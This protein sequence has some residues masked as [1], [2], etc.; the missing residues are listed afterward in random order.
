MQ[1]TRIPR[2]GIAMKEPQEL[3]QLA[4]SSCNDG[5]TCDGVFLDVE[6][7][8]AIIRGKPSLISLPL[9]NGE[10]TVGIPLGMLVEAASR[11]S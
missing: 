10:T 1:H 8:V 6:H 4:G 3:Q 7:G 2:E 5:A 11:V 9:G